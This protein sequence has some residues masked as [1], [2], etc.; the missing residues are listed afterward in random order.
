MNWRE[1]CAVVIPCFNESAHIQQVVGQIRKLLPTILV[2]D[3]G[4]NDGTARRANQ[5]GAH[6]ITH[7]TR[8]GKGAALMS[9]FVAAREKGFTHVLCLDGDGQHAPED[10]PAFFD[11]C[12]R[13]GSSLVIGNRFANPA[14]M[15]WLRRVTNICMS[16]LL[17]RVAG[18]QLPDTQC[19]FRLLRLSLLSAVLARTEHFEFESEFLIEVIRTGSQVEFVPIQTIYGSEQ[20]KINSARDT[21]RWFSWLVTLGEP[22]QARSLIDPRRAATLNQAAAVSGDCNS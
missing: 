20:S 1:Q 8:R 14:T 9:G 12:E 19:G 11:C 5:A 7:L 18:T 2:V 3:D 17:S 10:I 22:F 13:T 6:V 16:Q 15:P 4:S 21:I